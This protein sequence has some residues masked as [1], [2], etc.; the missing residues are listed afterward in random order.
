MPDDLLAQGPGR[1][2]GVVAKKPDNPWDATN[3]R[4]RCPG[5]PIVD[6]GF[7][8][9]ELLGHLLLEEAEVESSFADMTTDCG[10]LLRIFS[11]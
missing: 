11:W 9:P 4:I 7:V 10:E 2:E 8:D 1:R 6:G 5:F 3:P